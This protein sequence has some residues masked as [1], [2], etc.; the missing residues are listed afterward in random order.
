MTRLE[1]LKDITTLE[2]G[3]AFLQQYNFGQALESIDICT[4]CPD[5]KYPS[6]RAVASCKTKLLEAWLT[7]EV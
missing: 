2:Q 6:C 5:K 3:I 1:T 4:S 7:Q